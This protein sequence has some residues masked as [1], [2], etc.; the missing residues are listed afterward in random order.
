M[1][2][3]NELQMNQECLGGIKVSTLPYY[4]ISNKSLNY[5]VYHKIA[6]FKKPILAFQCAERKVHPSLTKGSQS[7]AIKGTKMLITNK[8]I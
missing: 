2:K 4:G 5:I 1:A 6:L 3:K 7:Y 8:N